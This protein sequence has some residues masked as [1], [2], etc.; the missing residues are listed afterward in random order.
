MTGGGVI[1][2]ENAFVEGGGPFYKRIFESRTK[3]RNV[4]FSSRVFIQ[5][6]LLF[7]GRPFRNLQPIIPPNS[8]MLN[9]IVLGC[10]NMIVQYILNDCS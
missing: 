1:Y 10:L 8:K 2:V 4:I 5:R 9:I 6:K 3:E 7:K